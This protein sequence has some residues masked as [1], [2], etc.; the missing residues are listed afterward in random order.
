QEEQD[1]PE[2]DDF[3]DEDANDDADDDDDAPK[4]SLM[5]AFHSLSD[6]GYPTEAIF[7]AFRCTST[8]MSLALRILAAQEDFVKA[9]E[10]FHI[11][12][13]VAGI[14]TPEDDNALEG[15]DANALKRVEKKHGWEGPG[16]CE[17]RLAFLEKWRGEGRR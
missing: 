14:W 3:Y 9:G 7:A 11:P 4:P 10:E 13:Q 6:S 12:A 5:A 1:L 15:Q 17:G 2:E 16:G 8:N